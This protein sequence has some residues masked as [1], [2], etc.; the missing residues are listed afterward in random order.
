[1]RSP[2]WVGGLVSTS[3]ECFI[4]RFNIVQLKPITERSVLHF[5]SMDFSPEAFFF[6]DFLYVEPHNMLIIPEFLTKMSELL[7]S[8]ELTSPFSSEKFKDFL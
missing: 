4:V 6:G 2:N 5:L 3:G 1:M 7:L 8:P